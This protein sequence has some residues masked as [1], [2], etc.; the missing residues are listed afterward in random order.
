MIK[1]SGTCLRV[2]S[3]GISLTMTKSKEGQNRMRNI[4]TEGLALVGRAAKERY[5]A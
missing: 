4:I 5:T 1:R 3:E 2:T